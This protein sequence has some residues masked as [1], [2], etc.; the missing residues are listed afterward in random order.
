MSLRNAAAVILYRENPTLEV[1]WVRRSREMMFMGGFY[2]F[3]GGQAEAQEEM[4]DCAVRELEEELG[5]QVDTA[6]LIP[7][8]RWVTPSFS[9]R[10]FDTCFYLA[11]CPD[12][13]HPVINSPELDQGAWIRPSDAIALWEEGSIMMAPPIRH[14]LK[15]LS[16]GLK[17]VG[18]RMTSDPRAQGGAINAIEMCK[19][20]VLVPVRTPTLP[21]ATH[22]NCYI[23][24]GEELIVID[25]ASPYPEEQVILDD[26]LAEMVSEGHILREIWLTHRHS[27]HIGGANHLRQRWNIPIAAH[28]ITANEVSGDVAVDR[29]LL[30]GEVVDLP[31]IP[32]CTL[33]VLHT[34][35]HA[36]G[37]I[38]VFEERR[39]SL[40]TGDLMAGIGTIVI[41]PP[42]GHMATYIQSLQLIEKLQPESLFFAHGPASATAPEKIREYIGHRVERESNILRAWESGKRSASLIVP[43][44]YIDVD[45]AMWSLAER[46]V[47]AHLEKLREE[48]RI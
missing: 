44:V 1:F 20:I 13:Q 39:R 26:V 37:H 30:D 5:V 8:G 10:R 36:R 3:P 31:G 9:P 22:T 43:E 15:A 29:L 18:E 34:P 4:P 6:A 48:G 23:V 16:S 21:P 7:V 12:G 38:C 17:E 45:N 42:E 33:K 35:G 11:S 28:E 32:G 25:P 40:I 41:D 14:A 27:D 47:T 46:S 24:G 2:A 19:G